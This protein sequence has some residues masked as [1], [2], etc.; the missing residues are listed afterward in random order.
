M[1]DGATG[2]FPT[3]GVLGAVLQQNNLTALGANCRPV[4]VRLM[5]RH[6]LTATTMGAAGA[7]IGGGQPIFE[8]EFGLGFSGEAERVSLRCKLSYRRHCRSSSWTASNNVFDVAKGGGCSGGGCGTMISSLNFLFSLSL[9]LFFVRALTHHRPFLRLAGTINYSREKNRRP[10]KRAWKN[11]RSSKLVAKSI[12]HICPSGEA[13]S[14]A[15]GA[16]IERA[17]THSKSDRLALRAVGVLHPC[18]GKI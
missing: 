18:T 2:C 8:Q 3:G 5:T 12:A 1:Y 4:C 9:F 6:T 10:S 15:G 16:Q 14:S 17:W 11:R 7:E 13:P